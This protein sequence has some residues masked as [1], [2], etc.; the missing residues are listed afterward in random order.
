[1]TTTKKNIINNVIPCLSFAE[2]IERIDIRYNEAIAFMNYDHI[3]SYHE[4]Y[5]SIRK[6]IP[7]FIASQTDYFCIKI[8][9]SAYFCMAFFAIV[10]SGKV[11]LLETP[12]QSI[13]EHIENITEKRI[14]ELMAIESECDFP[15]QYDCNKLAVIAKSSGTTSVSKGVM[16]S[17][18]NLLSDMVAG[19]QYYDYPQGAIYYNVLPYYHLFG[20]VADMLGPLYSG[21]I[22]CF[23]TNKLNFFNDLQ[24][25]KPSHMNLPPAMVYIIEQMIDKTNDPTLVTGGNLKKIM[26]AGAYINESS[27]KKMNKS[28]I[29]VFVAYGL[30]ECSP[31]VSMNC[32]YFSKA[33]SVG[34]VL[35]CCEAKILDGEVV[36]RGSNV[37]IG[38]WNDF[39]S[40][41]N[42]I[43]NGWLHTGDLGYFDDE[44]F[45]FLV[46]RKSNMIVF[47]NGK[48][49]I[50]EIIET[51]LC[52]IDNIKECLM[53]ETL[54]NNHTMVIITAVISS[55]D[56]NKIIEK[57]KKCL[58][59]HEILDRVSDIV[60]T[61]VPLPKNKLGKIIRIQK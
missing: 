58:C 61:T 45:L 50:P 15:K 51:E 11:A 16:L 39:E 7:Y 49:L 2:F 4:L 18:K 26:C 59:K 29:E 3:W 52:L 30:T 34:K 10:I 19:M 28:G 47:E 24:I 8:E 56:K 9:N 27:I 20:I 5:V 40:T 14:L 23:S 55:A 42:V 35:P 38:Y 12:D 6:L 31:C 43:Q 17:Q 37:M 25:F 44:G 22:I 13:F 53:T 48:K 21:G 36:V 57:I 41:N 60:L 46:G 32:D 54:S 1:M 33:G